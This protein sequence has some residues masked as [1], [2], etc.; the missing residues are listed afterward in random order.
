M[1][2]ILG[3]SFGIAP[4]ESAGVET[5]A[6]RAAVLSL[7]DSAES[8]RLAAGRAAARSLGVPEAVA[9][10]DPDEIVDLS[11]TTKRYRLLSGTPHLKAWLD[12]GSNAELAGD[13]VEALAAVEHA[14]WRSAH[15][16]LGVYDALEGSAQSFAAG[17]VTSL[18]LGAQGVGR[19]LESSAEGLTNLRE[20]ADFEAEPLGALAPFVGH[21]YAT[22]ETFDFLVEMTAAAGTGFREVGETAEEI[23]LSID[24]PPE[25]RSFVNDVAGGLGQVA[26]QLALFAAGPFGKATFVM[27][28]FG[29]GVEVQRRLQIDRG[30]DP[31]SAEAHIGQ[32]V[33]GIGSLVSERTSIGALKKRLQNLEKYTGRRLAGTVKGA[34]VEATQEVGESILQHVIANAVAGSRTHRFWT[35]SG[36]MVWSVAAPAVS[37]AT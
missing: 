25:E 7:T 6:S 23:A 22:P 15:P 27:L 24:V 26:G 2:E 9:D 5:K 28:A 1:S 29:Q 10:L 19:N 17:A 8:D 11:R 13:D 32:F 37:L 34:A 18:G 31:N 4:E 16:W 33:A 36:R 35:R 12:E 21:G 30:V 20:S 3:T 14:Y